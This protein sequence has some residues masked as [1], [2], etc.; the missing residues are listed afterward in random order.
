MTDN[1]QYSTSSTNGQPGQENSTSTAV[2]DELV[3]LN[4]A[5]N[6]GVLRT[7]VAPLDSL[8]R[9]LTVRNFRSVL[10]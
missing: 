7:R 5:G 8:S 10:Q 1:S 6:H 3:R 9:E 2:T 4:V